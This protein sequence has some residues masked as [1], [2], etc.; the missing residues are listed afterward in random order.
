M[1]PSQGAGLGLVI[2]VSVVL[3]LCFVGFV[4]QRHPVELAGCVPCF[5]G[6]NCNAGCLTQSAVKS[7]ARSRMMQ[8]A[9]VEKSKAKKAE[10]EGLFQQE[11]EIQKAN[12]KL[13]QLTANSDSEGL[14]NVMDEAVKQVVRAEA[15]EIK[16]RRQASMTHSQNVEDVY[17]KLSP[18]EQ[19]LFG[20]RA[21]EFELALHEADKS[22]ALAQAV[23]KPMLKEGEE[24]VISKVVSKQSA[25][26][27]KPSWTTNLSKFF[28]SVVGD[29][30]G[31]AWG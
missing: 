9:M 5:G 24:D 28:S 20:L 4:N 29:G 8:L 23:M 13:L 10:K 2:A 19:K 31:R 6:A 11:K 12:A 25:G 30:H 26:Q 21:K 17:S 15:A 3:A 1:G 7:S 27:A 22:I 18:A 14:A 16:L